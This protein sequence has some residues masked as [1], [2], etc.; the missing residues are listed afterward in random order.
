MRGAD[1]NLG[2]GHLVPGQPAWRP[3]DDVAAFE[4]DVGPKLLESLDM[5]IDGSRADR[6]AARQRNLRLS[7]ARHERRQH[8]E[9]R[10]HT[11]HHLIGRRGVDDLG[12]GQPEGL[13]V[14][15]A[16]AWPL[17][18][19]GQIDTV[20]AQDAGEQIDVGEPRDVVQRQRLTRKKA[21]N[22]QG[23][24]G[25]LGAANG[26]GASQALTPDNADLVHNASPESV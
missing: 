9:A 17:A 20:I 3:R 11:R 26:Y 10:A 16:L 21:R 12:G 18:G 23:Q 4:L 5:Q 19:K 6:A 2:Q 14:V 22:H 8:P 24:R 13:A 25:I 1:R 7:A 15:G